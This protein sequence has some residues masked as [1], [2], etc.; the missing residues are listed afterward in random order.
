MCPGFKK[1]GQMKIYL[2]YA[3]TAPVKKEVLLAIEP[4]FKEKFGNASSIH[5][6]GRQ[7][8]SAIDQS[9][10]AIANFFG[11]SPMEIIFTSSGTEADNLA[12][13]GLVLKSKIK[14]PHIITSAIEH[15][16]VIKTCEFLEKRGMAE[17]TY[18][19][20][21]R[22]GVIELATIEKAIKPN[23]I[24][25]SIMYVNNEIGTIQP[26]REIGKMLERENR[27]RSKVSALSSKIY[28]HTDA[29]QAAEYQPM[30]V[31]FLHVDMLTI[32]GHKIGTP[33]GIGALYVRKNTPLS[34]IIYGG[35][36]EMGLRAGTENVPYI[37]GLGKAVDLIQKSKPKNEE[38]KKLR[39]YYI[40]RITKEI[41]DV[42][43]NGS[44]KCRTPN[45]A[46]FY[47]KYIEGE[48]IV[49][50]LDLEGIACSTGSACTSQA[51]EPSH[52]IMAVFDDHFRAAGSVRFSLG[53]ETTKKEIDFAIE[54][55]KGVVAR[56]RKISPYGGKNEH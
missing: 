5:F 3:A 2:D 16:A 4:Y 9:R 22:E 28:F 33:K 14:K 29:V 50:S 31:D 32:S 12:I 52:V 53:E 45:N 20:P 34:S 36:Q 48:S 51:L 26:I 46:N 18:I 27:E 24:L 30:N 15:H 7:A 19:K 49:L 54:K 21:N 17:V 11:S 39:D 37:V 55:L 23:T 25:V 40:E 35:E 41:P 47:F 56:L 13:M 43:L 38:I 8:H 42:Y 1:A 44:Q 10:A 6:W